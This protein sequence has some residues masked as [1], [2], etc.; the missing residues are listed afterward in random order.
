M[1]DS[2]SKGVA[3][4]LRRLESQSAACPKQA[5]VLVGYSQGADV[6]HNAA[7]KL[8]K[9]LYERVVALVMYGDPGN[10]GEWSSWSFGVGG[11]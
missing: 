6:M 11:S 2:K 3:D 8:G 7:A 10:R 4:V 9:D 5:Y 1:A